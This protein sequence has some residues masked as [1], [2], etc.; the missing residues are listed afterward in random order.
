MQLLYAKFLGAFIQLLEYP[1]PRPPPRHNICK[2]PLFWI[3]LWFNGGI[4]CKSS[5]EAPR[6]SYPCSAGRDQG[7]K[8][9][10]ECLLSVY[11]A[12]FLELNGMT[13][14]VLKLN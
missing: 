11:K 1:I 3:F 8:K 10:Q 4:P 7:E 9:M 5:G 14:D 12:L 13:I 2:N 6:S